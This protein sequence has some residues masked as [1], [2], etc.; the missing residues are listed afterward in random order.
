VSVDMPKESNAQK[1]EN[2]LSKK[3]VKASIRIY[4]D[5]VRGQGSLYAPVGSIPK[6]VR[7]ILIT[8]EDPRFFRHKG[9]LPDAMLHAVL[10]G[11]RT[12]TPMPGGSTITQQLIK[13]LYLNEERSVRRKIAEIVLA[14]QVEMTPLLSKKEILEL[15]FNCVRYGP[16]VYGIADA[17]DY[18]FGKKPEKLTRNQAVILSTIAIS[19][20]WRRPIETPTYFTIY[21]NQSLSELVAFGAMTEKEARLIADTYDPEQGLDPELKSLSDIYGVNEGPKTPDGLVDYARDMVGAPYWKGGYGQTASLGLL[22]HRRW[23]HPDDFAGMDFL[24]DLGKR[25]FDDAGLIKGYLWSSKKAARPYRDRKQ[26]WNNAMLYKMSKNKGRVDSFDHLNGRLLYKG[27]SPENISHVGIYSSDG[28]VYHAKNS[29]CGVVA[30]TFRPKD[31]A[32]WSDVPEYERNT[33]F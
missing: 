3:K 7:R 5:K 19:P 25:V 1:G 10:Y 30:E 2:E 29:A 8:R 14:L 13:N 4:L 16:D 18:Y 9:I 27:R 32:F 15:Y 17:A 31:W 26:D 21:R 24:D 23:E 28:F 33:Y 22:N 12:H 20:F 6:D 11:L